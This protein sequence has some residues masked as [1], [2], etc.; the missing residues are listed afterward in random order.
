MWKMFYSGFS[1]VKRLLNWGIVN[2]TF[3]G[4]RYPIFLAYVS[5]VVV[6][7]LLFYG[8]ISVSLASLSLVFP[9]QYLELVAPIFPRN[10]KFC[11][12][13]VLAVRLIALSLS[14]SFRFKKE[15]YKMAQQSTRIF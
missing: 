6:L 13:V 3:L 10:L 8:V 2:F 7:T 5:A 15:I 14:W 12:S 9:T 11:M 1:A 4:V